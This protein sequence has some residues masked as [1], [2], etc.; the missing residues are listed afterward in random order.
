MG[1]CHMTQSSTLRPFEESEKILSVGWL[2][3]LPIHTCYARRSV[4]FYMQRK[5]NIDTYFQILHLRSRGKKLVF[6]ELGCDADITYSLLANRP[7]KY[8]YKFKYIFK[9]TF[10]MDGRRW[11]AWNNMA[12]DHL[13]LYKWSHTPAK[14]K[15]PVTILLVL[16]VTGKEAD[17]IFMSISIHD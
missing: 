6:N 16:G 11:R 8:Y 4:S 1:F 2:F 5:T 13:R 17:F 7:M 12:S 9:Y 14:L 15:S 10:F 3:R